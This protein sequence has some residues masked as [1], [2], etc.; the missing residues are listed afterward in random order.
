MRCLGVL[1]CVG[2]SPIDDGESVRRR[3]HRGGRQAGHEQFQRFAVLGAGVNRALPGGAL[4]LQVTVAAA[5]A[6]VT[7]RKIELGMTGSR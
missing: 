3:V 7:G 6:E 2:F 4:G 5:T 1:P